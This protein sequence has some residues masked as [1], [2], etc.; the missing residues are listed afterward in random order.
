M[1]RLSLLI[2]LSISVFIPG[3]GQVSL[4]PAY[5][6]TSDT[7]GNVILPDSGWQIMAD[8]GGKLSLQEV[9]NADHF[10]DTD[11]KVNYQIHTYWLR[12]RFINGM[13]K[14]AKIT[15]PEGAAYA[16]LYTKTAGGKWGHARTGTGVRWSRRDGLKRIHAF[17]LTIPAGEELV[18][19]KRVYWNYTAAQ[20]DS[21]GVNF[22]FTEDVIQQNYI[23]DDAHYMMAVQDA[24]LLGL[25]V[26]SMVLNFY[27]FLVVREKEFLFFSLFLLL[28][29]LDALS[30]LDDVFQREFPR[31]QLYLYI[32]SASLVGFIFI[33]FVRYFLKTFTRFPHW[34]KYLV[35]LSIF[36]VIGL[37][38]V[39]FASS[40]FQINL[41]AASHFSDNAIKLVYGVSLLITLSLY[42]RD[43]D[44][45]IRLMLIALTPILFLQ[46]LTYILAIIY[47]LYYSRFGAPDVS[48]YSSSFNK[49]AFF[50]LILCYLWMMGFFT[51][52][53]FLRFSKLRKEFAQQAL[54][55]NLKSRFF[56]NISHEF[57]TPLTLI[58]GPV[59]DLLQ[60]KG[61]QKFRAPLLNI[62]R[63]SK[64]L[65]QLINQLLDLSRVD[66][67]SYRVN[68]TREDIIPFVNQVVHSFTSL[69]ERKNIQLIVEADAPLKDR[70]IEG[71]Q[72]FYFDTDIL[73]KIL[74]NLL[75]N[76]FKFTPDGGIITVSLCLAEKEKGF[77]ELKVADTGAGIPADKLPFIFERF[78]QADDSSKRQYQGTGI[79]LSLVKELVALHQG[80]ITVSS[81][82]NK[83]TIFCC[84][85]PLNK[86]IISK[87][88]I[89][90][91]PAREAGMPAMPV[92]GEMITADSPQK[93]GNGE[94][95][96]LIVEDHEDVRNYIREKLQD[97][98]AI[99][100]A[101]N[102]KKG[103]QMATEQIPDLVISDV[104]MPEMDGFELC[105]SL[106]TDDRTSHIPVIL[107]TARAED[108]DKLTGL[109]T[110][111]DVYLVKPFNSRELKIR[112][113]NLIELRNKMRTKFSGTLMVKPS[114]I[115]VTSRDSAF[116]Q[117]LLSATESH[118]AD[119]DFSVEQLGQEVCMSVSQ[120]NR[121][122]KA[123]INQS[124]QQFI[125]SVRMERAKELLKNDAGT[126]A[127]IAFKSGFSDP[128]YFTRVFKNHFGCLPS[129]R[130]KFP[131]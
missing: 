104:M 112:V 119:E 94:P 37:L 108:A 109:E 52:V 38:S 124:A 6:I 54:L 68:T 95:I 50:I 106:K 20:P 66:A 9:L 83:G 57:R 56:A 117:N 86:K 118:I 16:D 74:Y 82:V 111:A 80:K 61:A 115:T 89:P 71:Q 8:P 84:Y 49:S 100:E 55:D 5:E 30:S 107:L 123:L 85:F 97:N 11:R 99:L 1:K 63:N 103:W 18:A 101:Q 31:L 29:S 41:A 35:V 28:A 87:E 48:G 47:H 98:Y 26:L 51:W 14:E 39:C 105:S 88:T 15:L 2:V 60:E 131:D 67:R 79:G 4:P 17:M 121:K 12:Y 73:E 65:L 33:H 126:I 24:F 45:I 78:Y 92:P 7:A 125:R 110:G 46:V 44:R 69:A 59:E 58:M 122:L 21:M 70:L 128:G 22:R 42:I 127:E 120:I 72:C 25:F 62:H 34:D 91:T 32:I 129:E 23:T 27:F 76:A 77:L 10:Q 43:H 90:R 13:Q 40:V 75:S 114:E 19:Y 96:V 102:G 64:R 81:E 116:M 36:Q 53:L 113:N 3:M 130:G 93:A